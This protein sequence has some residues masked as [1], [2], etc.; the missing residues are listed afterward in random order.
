MSAEKE[1]RLAP[2]GSAG[3]PFGILRQ[4]RSDLDRMFDDW[5]WPSLRW[6]SLQMTAVDAPAW[7]PTIEVFEKD[8]RLVTKVD[9]PGLKKEDVKVEVT[10]SRL[11]ISGERKREVEEKKKNVYRSE[12]EYGSFYRAVPLPEGVKPEDVKATFADGVLE[13]SVP[14]PARPEAKVR[15]VEIQEPAKA[16]R[17]AA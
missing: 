7:S 4:M 3:E 1:T 17:N 15:K 13:V 10:D 14:L 6:P 8:N 5:F 16:A 2:R 9:L 12:R 11:A